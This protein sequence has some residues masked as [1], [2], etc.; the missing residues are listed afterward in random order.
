MSGGRIVYASRYGSTAEV[1]EALAKELDWPAHRAEGLSPDQLRDEAFLVFGSP[2][3]GPSV[4]PAMRELL[5]RLTAKKVRFPTAA[6]VVCGDTLWNPRAQEGG[7]KNLEKLTSLIPGEVKA[8]AVFGGRMRME[9][10]NAEDHRRIRNFYRR[11]GK[12]PVGF[13]RMD[14]AA[15]PPFAAAIRRAAGGLT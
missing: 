3:Y 8:T 11:L 7:D 5:H 4:L 9:E 13:D 14:P 6:F 1:A 12:S 15:V 10:L 2:I